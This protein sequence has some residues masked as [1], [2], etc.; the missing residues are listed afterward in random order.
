MITFIQAFL[1][2]PGRVEAWFNK[3]ANEQEVTIMESLDR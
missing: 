2:D 1:V 3:L